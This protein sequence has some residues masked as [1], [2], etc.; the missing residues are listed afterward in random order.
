MS[1]WLA[2]LLMGV[3]FFITAVTL[4]FGASVV[5]VAERVSESRVDVI[6]ERRLVGLFTVQRQNVE[7][8]TKA[9]RRGESRITGMAGSKHRRSNDQWFEL[10][11]RDGTVWQSPLRTPSFGASTAE[12]VREINAVIESPTLPSIQTGW[13]P[14][15][16]NLGALV[17][18]FVSGLML[19]AIGEGL[20][21][22][23]GMI[24]DQDQD[25]NKDGKPAA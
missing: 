22:A 17:L 11:R 18:L 15:I 5:V 8:V 24:K 9:A 12:V 2:Y 19:M 10:V 4:F 14:L 25:Q 16:V 21:R 20:L 1:R 7:D 3:I 23:L 6:V 13:T